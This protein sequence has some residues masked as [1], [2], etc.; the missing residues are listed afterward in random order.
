MGS[1][2]GDGITSGWF[3]AE[4]CGSCPPLLLVPDAILVPL[5][6]QL[7]TL[8]IRFYSSC[9][10]ALGFSVLVTSGAGD[11]GHVQCSMRIVYGECAIGGKSD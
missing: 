9:L 3:I 7:R 1:C 2:K 6:A 4:E 10:S 5:C 11:G 8:L